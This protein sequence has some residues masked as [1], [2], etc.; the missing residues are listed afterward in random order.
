MGGRGIKEGREGGGGF[1][2]GGNE[3][4][5]TVGSVCMLR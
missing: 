3:F 2:E 1:G 4:L 5:R